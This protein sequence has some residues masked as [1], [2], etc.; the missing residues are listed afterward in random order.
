MLRLHIHAHYHNMASSG[1]EGAGMIYCIGN[2]HDSTAKHGSYL[3]NRD[4]H[5]NQPFHIY[6]YV[7]IIRSSFP[8]LSLSFKCVLL[9]TLKHFLWGGGHESFII[10]PCLQIFYVVT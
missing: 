4:F 10:H 7:V 3:N 6:T 1:R 9:V 5:I 8:N 2:V